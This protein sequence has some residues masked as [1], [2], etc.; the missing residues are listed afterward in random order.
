[1]KNR[2][3]PSATKVLLVGI[4]TR[5]LAQSAVKAGYQVISLDYF[6]DSD[7]PPQAEVYSL[8]RDFN[9]PPTFTNLAQAARSLVDNADYV[10]VESG[11]ENDEDFFSICAPDRALF[12]SFQTVRRVRNLR[13][14]CIPLAGTG[15]CIPQTFYPDDGLPAAGKYLIKDGGHSGGM[16]VWEWD[17]KTSLKSSEVLQAVTDGVLASALFFADGKNALLLGITRQFAGVKELGA[18]GYAWSGNVAPYGDAALRETIEKAIN[19]LTASFGLV[20]LNGIDFI[21]HESVPYLIEVNPR[22]PASF[23]LFERLLNINTFQMHVDACQGNLPA[24]LPRFESGFTW[25]KGI[26]YATHDIQVG[27][28]RTW[29]SDRLVDI[30]HAGEEIP[31][32]APVCTI[33]HTAKGVDACW[34]RILNEAE[35]LRKQ[36]NL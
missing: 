15:M 24:M 28:T 5:A 2:M 8:V 17:A 27:D 21:L 22:P 29:V 14:L 11:L 32:G 19:S 4:S 1:M 26:V 3:M 18:P 13:N 10:L 31:A 33:L 34:Q 30:P 36:W 23:E 6:G 25:G 16:G 20:G 7:Q 35:T 9:L 12:N